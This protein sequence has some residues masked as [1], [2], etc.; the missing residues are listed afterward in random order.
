[1]ARLPG[2]LLKTHMNAG[3]IAPSS[4]AD[5]ESCLIE[6]GKT[7]TEILILPGG[8]RVIVPSVGRHV[9]VSA[10]ERSQQVKTPM[11]HASGR[12]WVHGNSDRRTP[13]IVIAALAQDRMASQI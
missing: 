6:D 8:A 2:R 12:F 4:P 10:R 7:V 1:V 13:S 5:T 9:L 3:S 11:L